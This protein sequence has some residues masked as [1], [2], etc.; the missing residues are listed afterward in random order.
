M[1]DGC[2]DVSPVVLLLFGYLADAV[3]YRLR[4]R[5][6]HALVELIVLYR[7]LAHLERDVRILQSR[8]D[9]LDHR[10]FRRHH[11]LETLAVHHDLDL[12]VGTRGRD[13]SDP[14][15]DGLLI[16]AVTAGEVEQDAVGVL[17]LAVD[18]PDAQQCDAR[19]DE[20]ALHEAP[21]GVCSPC[22]GRSAG[23]M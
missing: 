4:S 11:E 8:L 6:E 5:H 20:Y 3:G 10:R 22:W 16:E 15:H 12:H 9:V 21:P 13:F 7:D 19:D 1:R 23:P 17:R 14:P 18:E 2:F